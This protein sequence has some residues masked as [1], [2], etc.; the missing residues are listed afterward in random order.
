MRSSLGGILNNDKYHYHEI[1]NRC[2]LINCMID[3]FI[4][5]HPAC[6]GQMTAWAE[7]AQRQLS[8]V[9]GMASAAELQLTEV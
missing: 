1:A 5:G 2:H 3:D 4:L 9:M 6:N 8:N 7:D